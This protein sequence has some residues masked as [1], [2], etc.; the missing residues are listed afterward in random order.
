MPCARPDGY[1]LLQLRSIAIRITQYVLR[2]KNPASKLNIYFSTKTIV[3]QGFS[4]C[5]D[6]TYNICYKTFFGIVSG[7]QVGFLFE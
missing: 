4:G 3:F 1:F 2:D 7:A 5:Q 6:M